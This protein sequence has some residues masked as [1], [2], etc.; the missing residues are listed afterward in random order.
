MNSP[1]TNMEVIIDIDDFRNDNDIIMSVRK[2][3]KLYRDKE[4][5][6]SFRDSDSDFKITPK[7]G[8]RVRLRHCDC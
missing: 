8:I 1:K 5:I 6:N 4:F 7:T 2:F 3:M